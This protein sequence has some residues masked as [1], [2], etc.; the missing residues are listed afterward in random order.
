[1]IAGLNLIQWHIF[2]VAVFPNPARRLWR[3]IKQSANGCSGAA[4]RIQLE[5][6]AQQ[7][8]GSDDCGGFEVNGHDAMFFERIRENSR[9]DLRDDAVD[10]S[11]SNA[12]SGGCAQSGTENSAKRT[13]MAVTA[14]PRR[15]S[16]PRAMAMSGVTL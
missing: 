16:S 7:N 1:M 6:L 8:Q 4:A 11:N 9:R 13:T 14:Y 10:I 5:H 15:T 2:F 3:K 12:Q